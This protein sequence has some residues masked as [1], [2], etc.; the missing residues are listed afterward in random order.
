M[1]LLALHQQSGLVA[2]EQGPATFEQRQ[3]VAFNID[4]DE[5]DRLA[6]FRKMPVQ[7]SDGYLLAMV[8]AALPRLECGA[9]R[10]TCAR[11][12]QGHLTCSG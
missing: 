4:L 12:M 1:A 6:A 3:L 10:G 9:R 7:S 5:T 8:R 2:L 11:H